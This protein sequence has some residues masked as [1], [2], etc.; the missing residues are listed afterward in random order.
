MNI[1]V[2]ILLV[3]KMLKETDNI[4]ELPSEDTIFKVLNRQK[5]IDKEAI[6]SA[7]IDDWNPSY[8]ATLKDGTEIQLHDNFI[9]CKR[10]DEYDIHHRFYY[11]PIKDIYICTRCGII[12][13]NYVD[14]KA[15]VGFIDYLGITLMPDVSSIWSMK[16][17]RKYFQ[18]EADF[19]KANKDKLE[20]L[21]EKC[22]NSFYKKYSNELYLNDTIID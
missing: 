17:V 15:E 18:R 14:I 16:D 11:V 2:P 21:R 20:S 19:Q 8:N 4:Y 6:Y 10:S 9:G 13:R 5:H 12:H 1:R 22:N 7:L 3:L